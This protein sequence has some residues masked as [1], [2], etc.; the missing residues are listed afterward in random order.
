MPAK[1][2]IDKVN[3][4]SCSHV[5][6]WELDHKEGCV[7]VCYLLSCG[8]QNFA[9]PWS[10]A[11]QA[12]LSLEFSMQEWVAIPFSRGSS[13]PGDRTWFSCIAGRFFTDWATREECLVLKNWCW[14]VVLEKTLESSLDS[15][16]IKLVHPKGNQSWIIIRRADAKGEAPILWPPVGKSQPSGKDPDAGKDWG[17]EE[18]GV[19]EDEMFQ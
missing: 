4:F 14:T 12:P 19:A 13:W 3:G 11:C 2:C 17:Q 10:V 8:V 5:Q 16:E 18:K 15:K 9:T 1:V 6:M 7:W